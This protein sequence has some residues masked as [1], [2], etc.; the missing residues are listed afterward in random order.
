MNENK[1]IKDRLYYEDLIYA[2][3]KIGNLDYT[4]NKTTEERIALRLQPNYSEGEQKEIELMGE[5]L[6]DF[7][8][9]IFLIVRN[10][11][12]KAGDSFKSLENIRKYPELI[13]EE[14]QELEQKKLE[15]STLPFTTNPLTNNFKFNQVIQE[16]QTDRSYTNLSGDNA[17][18]YTVEDFSEDSKTIEKIRKLK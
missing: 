6:S 7:E 11:G 5:E 16:D 9:D 18:S 12:K 15:V 13:K 17:N 3:K 2:I 1:E 4:E 10:I 14:L 8:L